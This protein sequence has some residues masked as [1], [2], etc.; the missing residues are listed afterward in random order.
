MASKIRFKR[1]TQA[2][3]LL[4]TPE[5]GEPFWERDRGRLY[6]GDGAT[7]G[8]VLVGPKPNVRY[9]REMQWL[10]DPGA[11]TV[12]SVGWAAPTLDGTLSSADTAGAQ[13]VPL[14]EHLAA[15]GVNSGCGVISAAANVSVDWAPTFAC[16][17]REPAS[18]ANI[19]QWSGFVSAN[20]DAVSDPGTIYCA[21]W[22]YDTS[23][24]GTAFWR[25]VCSNAGGAGVYTSVTTDVA[26][27]AGTTSLLWVEAVEDLQEIRFYCN[28]LLKAAISTNQPDGN[29]LLYTCHR[30]SNVTTTARRARWSRIAVLHR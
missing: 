9:E 14:L 23:V 28:G 2:Q 16:Q 8:G 17:M 26:K 3:R 15:T 4:F 30:T 21:A 18:V 5:Q 20:P 11:T 27:A 19:R 12:T 10:K 22:F 1:G 24:H 6:I 7:A 29:Q 13:G 25:C